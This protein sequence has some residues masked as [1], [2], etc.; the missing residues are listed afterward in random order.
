[1]NNLPFDT[2]NKNAVPDKEAAAPKKTT[3]KTVA[4]K[5]E[6]ETV[7]TLTF[8]SR[9]AKCKREV[10]TALQEIDLDKTASNKAGY[11]SL[12]SIYLALNPLLEKYN[13]DIEVKPYEEDYINISEENNYKKI[14][15]GYVNWLDCE[16]D[17]KIKKC[18][19]DMA[20]D[21]SNVKRLASMANEVQSYGACL[22]YI[23]RYLLTMELNLYATDLIENNTGRNNG[24][25]NN[26][27]SNYNSSNNNSNNYKKPQ[28][29]QQQ[30]QQKPTN[31]DDDKKLPFDTKKKIIK[32]ILWV[33][34]GE[35][36]DEMN[37]ILELWTAFRGK[38]GDD[39]SGVSNV[40]ELSEARANF[41]L[42]KL[43][44]EERSKEIYIKIRNKIK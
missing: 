35:D 36:T 22:T 1:M 21:M 29:Q 17:E 18:K 43:K 7:K 27:S 2:E 34:S 40:E 30:Q 42:G 3:K 23:R 4:K 28:Q 8:R 25:N 15:S 31:V 32:N 10:L 33:M 9:I 38:D 26:N 19:Y 24:S 44:K 39:V 11:F 20:L 14:V 5:E 37:K 6:A 41:L 16:D 12:K 13:L